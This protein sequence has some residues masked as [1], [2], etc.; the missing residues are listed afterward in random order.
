MLEKLAV[1]KF[2]R[3]AV[4]PGP[5]LVLVDTVWIQDQGQ[6]ITRRNYQPDSPLQLTTAI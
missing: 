4:P 6:A 5:Q 2:Q 3:A 1:R